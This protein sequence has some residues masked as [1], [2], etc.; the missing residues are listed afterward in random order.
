MGH[1]DFEVFARNI[2]EE[3]ALRHLETLVFNSQNEVVLEHTQRVLNH[4]HTFK[5]K[6]SLKK[7]FC[8]QIMKNLRFNS[9]NFIT[10]F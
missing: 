5:L 6:S 2:H 9:K 7:L 3:L 1:F 10:V 4:F 8:G